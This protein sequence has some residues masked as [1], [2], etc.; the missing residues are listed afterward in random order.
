MKGAGIVRFPIIKGTIKRRILVNLQADPEEVA[1]LLPSPFIPKIVDGTSILGVCLIRLEGIRPKAIK[2]PWGI[3]SENAA[4]RVAVEWKQPNGE[5]VE[6]VYIFRRDTNSWLNYGLGGRIFP[7]EH[8]RAAFIIRETDSTLNYNMRSSDHKTSLGF[9]AFRAD[10]LSQN[11]KFHS[12][13]EIS[14]FFRAGAVGY[15]PL[16]GKACVQGMCLVT[17]EWNMR[18]LSSMDVELPFF[19]NE[20]GIRKGSLR[21]D[22]I[23]IMENIP[24]EWHSLN[25]MML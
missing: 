12:M 22:S 15:S 4:H 1:R 6:G 19:H 23:V 3:T 5:T 9:E 20:L 2:A 7:G 11:S 21:F 10:I 25:V 13:D 24:H 14:A 16:T 18:P 8:H 17:Q